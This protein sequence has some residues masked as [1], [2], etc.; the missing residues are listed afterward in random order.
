[1]LH[2]FLGLL[3]LSC[4]NQKIVDFPDSESSIGGD[5]G[6]PKPWSPDGRELAFVSNVHDHLDIGV[7]DI[8]TRRVRWLVKNDRD[9][10]RPLWPP[11]G[12]SIAFLEN[13]EGNNQ[14]KTVA[15]AGESH[16]G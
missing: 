6:A 9:K 8:G 3:V 13:R 11:N 12:K 16:R 14:L 2:Y 7:L 5:L 15:P 4:F 10:S 1:M